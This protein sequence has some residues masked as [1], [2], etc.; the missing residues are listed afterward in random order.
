MSDNPLPL[1]KM[2]KEELLARLLHKE[3]GYYL[4][5]LDLT[6]QEHR[7]L[8]ARAPINE[9]SPILKQKKIIMACIVEV[10]TALR[11]L[12]DYWKN[13]ANRDDDASIRV[14]QEVA[15]LNKLMQE[16]LN[17]DL[18]SQKHMKEYM[19]SVG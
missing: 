2:T 6:Q 5:I 9:I 12:K 15:G 7:K 18:E 11:P 10:E 4:A 17:L 3:Y 8:K 14:K 19:D 1:E 13:K 16:I